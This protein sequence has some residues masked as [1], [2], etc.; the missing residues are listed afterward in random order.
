MKL[1]VIRKGQDKIEGFKVVEVSESLDI[2]DIVSNSCEMVFGP[3]ICDSFSFIG[4]K[5]AAEALVSKLRLN[6]QIVMGGTDVRS[7]CKTVSL[8]LLP[9]GD[10]SNLVGQSQ[11]MSSPDVILDLF[12]QLG[13]KIESVNIDGLHYEVKGRRV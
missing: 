10:A 7:F 6:G 3:D 1:H 13:L 5:D 2:S 4:L 8:G 9:I 11:S 12:N